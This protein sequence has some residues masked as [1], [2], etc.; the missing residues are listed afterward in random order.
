MLQKFLQAWEFDISVIPIRITFIAVMIMLSF[1]CSNQSSS[2]QQLKMDIA[3]KLMLDI[4]Y[5]CRESQKQ[6]RCTEPVTQLPEELSRMIAETGIGGVVLFADNLQSIEQ[7]L[8]LNH[9]LQK[10]AMT[11]QHPALFI[12]ID[13]EG[14]RVVRLPEGLGTSFGGNMAIGATSDK[15][16]EY[17]AR[18][19]GSI[20]GSELMS[21]GFN[22]NFAPTVDVNVNPENPVINVRSY[23]ESPIKVAELGLAQMNAMQLQGIISTL[24]HFPGHGDTSVDSHTGLPRVSHSKQQIDAVDLMP[25][26]YAIDN[27]SPGMIMTAHIQY[28]EL[29]NSEFIDKSGEKTILPATMSSKILTDVL[30]NEMGYQG[31]II[32]D[33]LDMAGISMFYDHTEAVMQTF[34]AGADIAL[35]PLEIRSPQ[36][37]DK[38]HLLIDNLVKAANKGELSIE[39]VRQSSNRISALKKQYSIGSNVINNLNAANNAAKMV[40]SSH[41]SEIAEQQLADAAITEIKNN[42]VVPFN[43]EI[44]KIH[45]VMPDTTKCLAMTYALKARRSQLTISCEST[46]NLDNLAAKF[47]NNA[48]LYIAAD[49]SPQQSLVE[50]GG[51]DDITSWRQRPDKKAQIDYLLNVAARAK[52]NQKPFIFVN[53]RTPYISNRFAPL[54]DAI[55]ATYA[56][57]T[58]K[59]EYTDEFGRLISQFEGPSFHALA[60]VLLGVKVAS[61]SLPVSVLLE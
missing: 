55:F 26:Q 13:Q 51:M 31:V 59:I 24:K 48:D 58:N 33:A 43:S 32:T 9:D 45:L 22:L 39:E 41:E 56:Y 6:Q 28:P 11:S 5:F 23:G 42:G 14:G 44:N 27:S 60:D 2:K 53:L 37:I 54:S 8:A 50:L 3:Q 21:L 34:R 15:H 25:F 10:A 30:R 57:N 1:S 52:T 35:M 12:A 46:A 29:D 49:I 61:G 40:L 19:S 47:P 16:G 4:R 18:L 17:Y 7:I 36:D 38:L 20:I